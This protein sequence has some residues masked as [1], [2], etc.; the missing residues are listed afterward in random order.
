MDP[1]SPTP[2]LTQAWAE[3]TSYC[4]STA[5]LAH[6]QVSARRGLGAQTQNLARAQSPFLVHLRVCDSEGR[7][8]PRVCVLVGIHYSL[9]ERTDRGMHE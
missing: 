4:S 8:D 7:D 2:S 6:Q 5:H 3:G 1:G 9:D